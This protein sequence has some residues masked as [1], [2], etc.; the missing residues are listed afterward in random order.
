MVG[1]AINS[2]SQDVEKNHLKL[3]KT[4]SNTKLFEAFSLEPKNSGFCYVGRRIYERLV[5]EYKFVIN[6]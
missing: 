2:P 6:P 3:R 5:A 4:R 1:T